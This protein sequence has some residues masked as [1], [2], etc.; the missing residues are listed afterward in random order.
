LYS[1]PPLPPSKATTHRHPSTPK[2]NSPLPPQISLISVLNTL[3]TY[4]TPSLVLT[5]RVYSGPTT[6]SSVQITPL[7]ARTFG[8]WTFLSAIIRLY[9][10]Y[11]IDDKD[12]Y[13]LALWTYVIALAH[14]GSEWA[15]YGTVRWGRG[16]APSLGI[17]VGSTVWM[18]AQ[19]GWY[20]K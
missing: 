3:Q 14:F 18:V 17:A 4:T 10:A 7:S 15:V 13:A 9:A 1:L 2:T 19:W 11:R 6:L 12:I 16:I 8:T 5:R 20:V